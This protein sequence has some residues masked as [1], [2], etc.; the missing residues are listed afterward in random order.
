MSR[1][2]IKSEW[3]W[4]AESRRG[5]SGV[6]NERIGP[7][8]L[9]LSGCTRSSRLRGSPPSCCVALNGPRLHRIAF[10]ASRIPFSFG[11]H[12]TPFSGLPKGKS[13]ATKMPPN[14]NRQSRPGIFALIFFIADSVI[15][16]RGW[17]GLMLRIRS[18]LKYEPLRLLRQVPSGFHFRRIGEN[19]NLLESAVSPKRTNDIRP[20]C[21]RPTVAGARAGTMSTRTGQIPALSLAPRPVDKGYRGSLD[22]ACHDITRREPQL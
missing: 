14:T 6:V 16:W 22:C 11:S 2:T 4:L 1:L 3:Y 13:P 8:V 21:G 12:V 15:L 20:V 5:F 10:S 9:A 7:E 19:S 18:Q 17:P